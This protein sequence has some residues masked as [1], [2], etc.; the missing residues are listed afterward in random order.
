MKNKKFLL[1][2]VVLGSALVFTSAFGSAAYAKEDESKVATKSILSNYFIKAPEITTADL[3]ANYFFSIP[4]QVVQSVTALQ[5]TVKPITDQLKAEVENDKAHGV[6]AKN[7]FSVGAV[8]PT[9]NAK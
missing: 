4:T 7:Y 8:T 6:S 5:G 9:V 3:A 1:G 2:S